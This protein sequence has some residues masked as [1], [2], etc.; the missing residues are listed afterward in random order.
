MTPTRLTTTYVSGS[1]HLMDSQGD[2]LA[3][4]LNFKNS[5]LTSQDLHDLK[6]YVCPEWLWHV[7][8][9]SEE[10]PN[11]FKFEHFDTRCAF[12]GGKNYA[13]MHLGEF[14][15]IEYAANLKEVYSVVKTNQLD[16]FTSETILGDSPRSFL[17]CVF[18]LE[19]EG[20]SNQLLIACRYQDAPRT[21]Y[22]VSEKRTATSQKINRA[23]AACERAITGKFTLQIDGFKSVC[24][25]WD[26]GLNDLFEGLPNNPIYPLTDGYGLDVSR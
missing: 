18:P 19:F 21:P 24:V 6:S 8:D 2:A 23:I 17:R 16:K 11:A 26:T 1:M 22:I 14:D 5:S 20:R 13:G 25:R 12:E 7:V 10:N 4:W 15:D 9:A 3:R